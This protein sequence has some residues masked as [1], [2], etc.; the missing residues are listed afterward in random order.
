MNPDGSEVTN[1]SNHASDDNSPSW[2]PDGTRI[3]FISD[4]DGS[5]EIFVM[6]ADGSS[7][8]DLT[9]SPDFEGFPAW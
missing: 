9:N 2:S 6:D 3:V 4:R 7:P 1:L 5:E 8:V